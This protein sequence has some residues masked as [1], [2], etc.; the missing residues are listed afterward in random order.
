M[1]S[2]CLENAERLAGRTALQLSGD[3]G[4]QSFTYGD[5]FDAARQVALLIQGRL[6]ERGNVAIL[7][8]YDPHW[9]M[10]FFGIYLSGCCAVP[11]DTQLSAEEVANVVRHCGARLV[12]ADAAH[13][14]KV[15]GLELQVVNPH[16]EE[17][18]TRTSPSRALALEGTE[19]PRPKQ[20][21]AG[22][23]DAGGG[24]AG[25]QIPERRD[26]DA[27]LVI[28][29]TSG[30]TGDPKGVML[31]EANFL[32]EVTT[33]LELVPIDQFDHLLSILPLH[34]VLALLTNLLAPLY[35]GATVTF[36][37][38][39]ERA[40]VLR[41]L[42]QLGVTAF[43]CVPQFFYLLH[44]HV[45]SEISRKPFYLRKLIGWLMQMNFSL[46]QHGMNLGRW[47]F[48][49]IHGAF[50]KRFRFFAA[51]GSYFDPAVIRDLAAWGLNIIQAY[52]L[53][54][55]SGACI[56]TSLADQQWG[57][58][59]RP[60]RGVQVRILNPNE[61]G[62]GEIAIRGPIVTSGY[63]RNEEATRQAFQ[64]GWFLSG[65]LGYRDEGGGYHI[66]GRLKEVIVLASGKNIYPEELEHH[67]SRHPAIKEVAITARAGTAGE[68]Q[69]YAVVVPD[70][71]YLKS[72]KIANSAEVIRFE[73]ENLASQLPSYKRVR[74]L[75][76][77]SEP[78]PRTT[79]RKLKRRELMAQLK[80]AEKRAAAAPEHFQ[81]RVTAET[82]RFLLRLGKTPEAVSGES[83]LELDFGLDSLQ[84]V[85]LLSHLEEV[86][87][88]PI[89]EE[90]AAHIYTLQDLVSLFD[91]ETAV[92]R[93]VERQG[94]SWTRLLAEEEPFAEPFLRSRPFSHA[95]VNLLRLFF[96]YCVGR[97]FFKLSAEGLENLP[98]AGPYL[99]CP[100]HLSYLDGLFF[101]S[102]FPRAVFDRVFFLG[103][104]EYFQAG[105]KK[106]F[107]QWIHIVPLDPDTFLVRALRAGAMGLRRRR[108]LCIFPEGA[109]SIDGEVKPFK[110][111]ASILARESNVSIIPAAIAGTYEVWPRHRP[112]IHTH[113]VGIIFGP[114]IDPAAFPD[115]ASLTN[116]VQRAVE[117]LFVRVRQ[118]LPG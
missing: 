62:Q 38:T 24:T 83:N 36:L 109:R 65:D 84:R 33:L 98:P 66:T 87:G 35:A 99:I 82:Y 100:N 9:V 110:H 12:F 16:Q 68:E 93:E 51:G 26:P 23:P 14:D 64:D 108:I 70:F 6:P 88:T 71:E 30:T 106:R 42:Q 27:P 31:S 89:S 112:T 72:Q 53:T 43:V 91:P 29:Y 34:H 101:V 76:I 103:Y 117:E 20:A 90:Q 111:G 55:T 15:A 107:A 69:L 37:A 92:L 47:L 3:Q 1:I 81:N 85:E 22:R 25:N 97:P 74:G 54:E 73:I 63:F 5:V 78:L 105:F 45:W 4:L 56:A 114:P 8:N 58:V 18:F 116:E 21:G 75:Q 48:P 86:F 115:P 41:A 46:R 44:A 113:P 60:L 95:V 39:P 79:T 13:R 118:S 10:V 61:E 2:R 96:R 77:R 80:L 52:G 50:G 32:A 57:S 67:Y 40:R 19:A 104:S 94:Q 17:L 59:G 28:I 7:M 102:V 11:L 49:Q